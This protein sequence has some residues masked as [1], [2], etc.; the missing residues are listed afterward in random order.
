MMQSLPEL[1]PLA[2]YVHFPWCL[3]K[4]PYCDFNSHPQ[5]AGMDNAAL[6]ARYVQALLADIE[7]CLPLAQGRR[8]I[9]VFLGGGT[10]SLFAPEL[11]A[12]FLRRARVIAQKFVFFSK[13]ACISLSFVL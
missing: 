5:R 7:T 1:P 3:K 4:C 12:G 2:L 11:I 13:R 6:H 9:S 10:P 8:I